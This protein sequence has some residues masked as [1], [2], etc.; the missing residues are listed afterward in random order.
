MLRNLKELES[1]QVKATDGDIGSVED[2]L[3]DD[4]RWA[5]RYLV[6]D[7]GEFLDGRHV[8][9]S[10][11]SFRQVDWPTRQFHLAL[12]MA[13]IEHCPGIDVDQPVSRQNEEDINKYYG[14]PDYWAYSGLWGMGANPDLI[15][16]K[17]DEV[18]AAR[19]V[20]LSEKLAYDAHLQS[21][22][23]MN[24]FHIQGSDGEIGHV[25]GFLVDDETW[26]VRYLV[27]ETG[28]WW[29]G[30]KVLVAPQWATRVSW[31]EKVVQLERSREW[32]KNSPAWDSGQAITRAYE[33]ELHA[34]AGRPAYWTGGDHPEDR[35]A[36][37]K[38]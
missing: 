6:V 37:G 36:P 4:E 27:I 26:A 15:A 32:I 30:K 25:E 19:T 35:N 22:K 38:A 8:L 34:H 29:S 16:A 24:G 20:A 18:A 17:R 31:E 33:T 7:T 14:Y 9:I 2:F 5:I 1:F 23:A 13:K 21:T 10:P 12:T 3:L 11:L 28:H